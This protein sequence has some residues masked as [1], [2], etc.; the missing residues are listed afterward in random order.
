MEQHHQSRGLRQYL[1]GKDCDEGGLV[2]TS[3]VRSTV[4]VEDF[5]A[6]R[7]E[8]EALA[9]PLSAEDQQI[10]SMVDCSPTKWHR[11]HTTWFFETF[12]LRPHLPGYVEFDPDHRY[13]YNSYYELIGDR[14]PRHERG[15]ITRPSAEEV[16]LYRAHVDEAMTRLFDLVLPDDPELV[17]LVALGMQHEQQHQ[18]LLLSDIK[19]VLSKNPTRPAYHDRHTPPPGTNPSWEWV[20]FEGGLVE[21]GVSESSEFHFDNE[22]PRHLVHLEPFRL[23]DRLVT[24]GDWL[25]FMAA[26]GYH[27]SR[28]WLSEGWALVQQESWDAPLYWEATSSGWHTHTMHGFV[29]IDPSEPVCHIS[30]FEA[31]AFAHWAGGRLP[32]EAEWEHAARDI[33]IEGNFAGNRLL[34]PAPVAS[35][36]SGRLRQMFGDVWEWTSSSY[37]PY[38]GFRAPDGAVGE[39]NGKFMSNQYV[40]RGGA[41]ITPDGHVRSTYRNFFPS[42][43]RWIFSG[44]RLASDT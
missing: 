10:Q 26:D 30:H 31:D 8:T 34:Q 12:L 44:L 22:G 28:H 19:H 43:S 42:A 29:P 5:L 6:V 23:A 37:S 11:A 7:T 15:L 24:N 16:G 39:Y 33:D 27:E 13:L 14:H 20:E 32:T 41:A 40:L 35:E 2:T 21:I 38:P 9:A 17:P 36:S 1:D 25:D 18:E 3:P 4:A